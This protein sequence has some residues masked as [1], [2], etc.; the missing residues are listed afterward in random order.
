MAVFQGLVG[1]AGLIAL[2]WAISENRRAFPWRTA[3]V[4]SVVQVLLALLLI[5][6]PG[7]HI[8]FVWIGKAV[9]ALVQATEAGNAFLISRKPCRYRGPRASFCVEHL[10]THA[11]KVHNCP[12]KLPQAFNCTPVNGLN[13]SLAALDLSARTHYVSIIAGA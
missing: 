11:S 2:A 13:T 1:I 6:L 7:T 9:G 8:V 12:P 4:G 5:K 3:A 10:C